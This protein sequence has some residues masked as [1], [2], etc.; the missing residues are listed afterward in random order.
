LSN[1]CD[2]ELENKLLKYNYLL[3]LTGKFKIFIACCLKCEDI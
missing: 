1:I 3:Y 2:K